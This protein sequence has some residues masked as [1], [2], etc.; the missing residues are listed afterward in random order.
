MW[1]HEPSDDLGK[2]GF[3]DLH[4]GPPSQ[5]WPGRNEHHA[6]QEDATARWLIG[7]EVLADPGLRLGFHVRGEEDHGQVQH[8]GHPQTDPRQHVGH[9]NGG[10][11]EAQLVSHVRVGKLIH[12]N[13]L[14]THEAATAS[15]GGFHKVANRATRATGAKDINTSRMFDAVGLRQQGHRARE[16]HNALVTVAPRALLHDGFLKDAF[17]R[18]PRRTFAHVLKDCTQVDGGAHVVLCGIG[19]CGRFPKPGG[20]DPPGSIPSLQAQLVRRIAAAPRLPARLHELHTTHLMGRR[21]LH[22]HPC[23][24]TVRVLGR[25]LPEA[26][27]AVGCPGG[28]EVSIVDVHQAR[29]LVGGLVHHRG[30][31]EV[32]AP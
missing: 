29:A 14:A 28:Q 13:G 23:A 1:Q 30:R 22:A 15:I 21:P 25:D 2:L 11:F 20:L 24:S 3:A 31:E 5:Q 32:E 4:I 9:P 26:R 7:V 17:V 10:I 18:Q 8:D 16:L 19:R 27:P 6:L 12:K